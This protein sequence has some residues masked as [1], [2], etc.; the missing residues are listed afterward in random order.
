MSKL[1]LQK[2]E[3][4]KQYAAKANSGMMLG[5]PVKIG[6]QSH[7]PDNGMGYHSTIKVFDKDRDHLHQIHNLAQHLPLNSP[8][9]KNTQIKFDVFKDR[10]GNDVHVVKL[11]GNSAE[12]LKEHHA[13]FS[14][15]GNPDG[16]EWAPHISVD[17]QT[18]DRL[19]SSG[20]K[21][22]HEAGIS[23]GNAELKQGPKTIKTYHHKPD[24]TEPVSP[25]ESDFTSKTN[26]PKTGID[27]SEHIHGKKPLMKPFVSGAQRRWG[28]TAAG[29]EALGGEAGVHEWD[30]ATKEKK[31]PERV[32]KSEDPIPAP[33]EKTHKELTLHHGTK[34]PTDFGNFDMKHHASGFYPGVYTSSNSEEAAKH[35]RPVKVGFKGHL[36]EINGP[37]HAEQLHQYAGGGGSGHKLVQKLKEK[38]YHG[39]K[40]GSEHIIFDPKDAKIQKSELLEKGERGDW[41][42]EGYKIKSLPHK[43]FAQKFPKYS[44]SNSLLPHHIASPADQVHYAVSPQNKIVGH[45][46]VKAHKNHLYPVDSQVNTEHQRKGLAT[47]LYSNA[48]KHHEK[49]LKHSDNPADHSPDAQKLW[50]QPNR[51]FGKT[52]QSLEKGAIKNAGIA[53]GMAGALAGAAPTKTAVEPQ[54]KHQVAP[55]Y[56]H[57]KMLRAIA[58]V[59][60]NNGQNINHKPTSNGT[61][62]GKYALMPNTIQD[63][64]K[65]HKD[66][67]TKYGRAL[68]LKGDQLHRFM[69][70]NR[71]L[72]DTIA[73]R[74]LAHIEHNFKDNQ[75]AIGYSW[76]QGITGAKKATNGKVDIS[77]H[78]Y[79]KKI[80]EAYGKEK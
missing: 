78:P 62:Y 44:N 59:E 32:S 9:A 8:D 70:D 37:K 13:K 2:A 26:V 52:E 61:A 49:K 33:S 47:A 14:H 72:E 66:L 5:Y 67:K 7:R 35:G 73:D 1:S 28:H 18:H 58:A 25:D 11:H 41:K 77:K 31:L 71:G 10:E 45:V 76:N 69:Q 12:K 57:G 50:A 48:E 3:D 80:H 30:E 79:V 42:K 68:A 16:F 23:F 64:I 6:G 54:V 43:E 27:K 24:T 63:T 21:T 65:G 4:P 22:A 53:L 20:A 36:F 75:D 55:S 74:H 40:R 34:S 19:K 29:K 60:S 46:A 15:M 17:K 39:I 51:P 56:D 38:G